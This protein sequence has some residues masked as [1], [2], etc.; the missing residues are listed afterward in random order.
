MVFSLVLLMD[1]K[2][3]EWV[4]RGVAAAEFVL[5]RGELVWVAGEGG[6]SRVVVVVEQKFV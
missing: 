1:G 3:G 6:G 4:R 5:A 2:E